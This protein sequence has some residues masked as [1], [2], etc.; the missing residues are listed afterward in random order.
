MEV[1]QLTPSSNALTLFSDFDFKIFQLQSEIEFIKSE[2]SNRVKFLKNQFESQLQEFEERWLEIITEESSIPLKEM[3]HG[4]R[5]YCADR[6]G[7]TF[8]ISKYSSHFV[9][10]Y[11]MELFDFTMERSDE[12]EDIDIQDFY[13]SRYHF[14]KDELMK[15]NIVFKSLECLIPVLV[16][17][18]REMEAMQSD[19][20][21]KIFQINFELVDFD[22]Q[23]KSLRQQ[24]LELRAESMISGNT[25]DFGTDGY[26]KFFYKSRAFEFF[27]QFRITSLSKTGKTCS[28]EAVI[29]NRT[30]CSTAYYPVMNSQKTVHFSKVRVKTLI[31]NLYE[32]K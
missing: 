8:D 12:F 3:R 16:K 23:L 17:W 5:V 22:N 20:Q 9:F 19:I 30:F 26:R 14:G 27:E 25:I 21:I 6:E 2:R 15:I 24:I 29:K 28:I 18:N 1:A 4:I 7:S 13:L 32:R 10:N 31:S 11:M